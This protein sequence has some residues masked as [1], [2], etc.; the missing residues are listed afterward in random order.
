MSSTRKIHINN[1]RECSTSEQMSKRMHTL[2]SGKHIIQSGALT[3]TN[4]PKQV[5]SNCKSIFN[6]VFIEIT[7]IQ[8]IL[9]LVLS[10]IT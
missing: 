7:L 1:Q 6:L 10:Y 2:K 3:Q 5:I 8:S 9:I 4:S